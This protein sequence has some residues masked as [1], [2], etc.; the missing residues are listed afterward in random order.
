MDYSGCMS[1]IGI[2]QQKRVS[3]FLDAYTPDQALVINRD[4][5]DEFV[6]VS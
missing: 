5:F 1:S 6:G 2:H 3:S 4:D